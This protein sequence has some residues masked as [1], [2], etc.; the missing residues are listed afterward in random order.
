MVEKMGFSWLFWTV[1]VIVIWWSSHLLSV[2]IPLWS[3]EKEI[4][5]ESE[6]HTCSWGMWNKESQVTFFIFQGRWCWCSYEHVVYDFLLYW[7][8]IWEK[9]AWVG[10]ELLGRWFFFVQ[11]SSVTFKILGQ[12]K[13]TKMHFRCCFVCLRRTLLPPTPSFLSSQNYG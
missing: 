8:Q 12:S 1:D 10:R 3:C 9:K 4:E 7:F 11:Y 5:N 6:N 2:A 13:S